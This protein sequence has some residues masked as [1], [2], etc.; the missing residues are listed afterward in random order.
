[1][2]GRWRRLETADSAWV[3]ITGVEGWG[4]FAPCACEGRWQLGVGWVVVVR[5]RGGRVVEVVPWA[6]VMVETLPTTVGVPPEA[7]RVAGQLGGGLPAT[8]PTD[9]RFPAPPVLNT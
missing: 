3:V 7:G 4:G 5:G 9:G 2:R 8:R 6:Q 1:M